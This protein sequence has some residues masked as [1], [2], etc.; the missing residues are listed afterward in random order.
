MIQCISN[1]MHQRIGNL[2]DDV[3]IHLRVL[4]E[5]RKIDLFLEFARQ[6]SYQTLHFVKKSVKGNHTQLHGEFLDFT[7]N[8]FQIVFCLLDFLTF[9][10]F[11]ELPHQNILCGNQL[12]DHIEEAVHFFDVDADGRCF[13]IGNGGGGAH[14]LLRRVA[15]LRFRQFGLYGSS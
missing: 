15:F 9:V 12:S 7:R 14:R 2:I 10:L 13:R 8:V 11:I 1:N 4:A 3:A 5:N 6:I